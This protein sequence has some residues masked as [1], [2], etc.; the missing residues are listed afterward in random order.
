[1]PKEVREA[2]GVGPG[3]QLGYRIENGRVVLSAIK[4]P[5]AQDD[6]FA[7]FDEWASEADTKGM[8]RFERWHVVAQSASR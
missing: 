4:Q 2:L 3:D 6:P 5:A 8:L 7:C 1:M